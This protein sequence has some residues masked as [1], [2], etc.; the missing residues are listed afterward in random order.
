M[1]LYSQKVN[2][3]HRERWKDGDWTDDTDHVVVIIQ[4]LLYN[5]GEV[6]W[7]AVSIHN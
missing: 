2:D 7:I 6:R 1:L 4:S 3:V 5:K